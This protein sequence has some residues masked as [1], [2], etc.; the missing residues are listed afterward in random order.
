MTRKEKRFS[1]KKTPLVL[2]QVVHLII[3]LIS[4]MGKVIIA[5][6][7]LSKATRIQGEKQRGLSG[8]AHGRQNRG[9]NL[10]RP[11]HSHKNI[12]PFI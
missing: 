1:L 12:F 7:F 4:K 10:V 2:L 5:N 8:R 9:G 6:L 3:R 11:K